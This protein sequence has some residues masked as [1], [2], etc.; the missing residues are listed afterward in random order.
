VDRLSPASAIPA[1]AGEEQGR[2]AAGSWLTLL[3]FF[4]IYTC[5]NYDRAIM[6]VVQEPIKH[7]FGLSD[8]QLGALGGLVHGAMFAL[9]G[10]PAGLLIDRVNR[11]N[12]LVGMMIIWSLTTALGALAGGFLSLLAC[13]MFVGA[14]EA[15]GFPTL[16]TLTADI[17]PRRR[18]GTAMG[19]LGTG[20]S[21]GIILTLLF[22]G[23]I[24][25]SYGWRAGLLTAGVPGLLLAMLTL[26]SVREPR[27]K[28]VSRDAPRA[29]LG[30]AL[31]FI[32]S[33]RSMVLCMMGSAMGSACLAGF[34]AWAVSFLVR[35][36][37]LSIREVGFGLAVGAGLAGLTGTMLGGVIADLVGAKDPRRRLYLVAGLCLAAI[38]AAEIAL[39]ADSSLLAFLLLPIFLILGAGYTSVIAAL[40]AN[41]ASPRTRGTSMAVLSILNNALGT[42]LG[43][44]VVGLLSD[45]IGGETSLRYA[46][47]ILVCGYLISVLCFLL[48]ARRLPA[49]LARVSATET[50]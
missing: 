4:L 15:G 37:G 32:L 5:L 42:A 34:W 45:A 50:R 17:F 30:E 46:L 26:L 40:V 39:F 33:Q 25:Q 9:F 48:A 24:V 16:L 47:A 28:G 23:M 38:P 29:T 2:I 8:S 6:A 3:L 22:G 10:L 19:L 44:F 7:E 35:V 41:L 14:A 49:D 43:P 13:R 36:H 21:T 1:A 20:S 18:H 31:R 12:L 11:R 27:R